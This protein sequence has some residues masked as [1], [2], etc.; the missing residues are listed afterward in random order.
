MTD[1]AARYQSPDSPSLS[2][3]RAA[4]P[5]AQR[6]M[7]FPMGAKQH[8]PGSNSVSTSTPTMEEDMRRRRQD[9]EYDQ[10]ERELQERERELESRARELERERAHLMT[11]HEGRPDDPQPAPLSPIN[12]PRRV[13]LRKHMQ[14]PQ[15]QMSTD[16]GADSPRQQRPQFSG[17]AATPGRYPGEDGYRH[18]EERQPQPMANE[19]APYCGCHACSASKY[20]TASSPSREQPVGG[21]TLRPPASPEK[22]KGW[23]RRLSMPGGLSNAFSSDAKRNSSSYALG[24]GVSSASLVSQKKGILSF[25]GRKNSSATNLLR[26]PPE[27]EIIRRSLEGDRR[28]Q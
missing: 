22:P 2:R 12:R 6:Q 28:R 15:S 17:N 18:S 14:R 21:N 8:R 5:P 26:P 9:S 24:S 25:D 10:R 7:S 1:L 3:P 13:S 19:H 16:G 23:M 11:V 20:A 4:S 27:Q